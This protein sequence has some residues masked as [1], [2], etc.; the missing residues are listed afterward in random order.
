MADNRQPVFEEVQ[1]FRHPGV[2][3][4]VA[5]P[6]GFAWFAGI[7]QVVLGHRFGTDPVPDWVLTTVWA[8]AGMILPLW[9]AAL[10][11]V[12]R[13]DGRGVEVRFR[14]PLS[15]RLFPLDE[16]VRCE[17]VRY[18]PIREFSGW[19]IRWGSRRGDVAVELTLR[20]GF[21]FAVGSQRPDDLEAAILA[22]LPGGETGD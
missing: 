15:G 9:L 4:L 16:I 18:L 20:Q 3:A 17:Q 2:W 1:R 14:P 21:R 5:V 22:R 8:V 13:V 6:V 19:G 11:L 7:W 10:R 12:T